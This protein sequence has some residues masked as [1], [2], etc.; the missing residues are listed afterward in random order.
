MFGMATVI[1]AVWKGMKSPS[2]PLSPILFS[3]LSMFSFH[4]VNTAHGTHGF[5]LDFKFEDD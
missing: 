3:F 2:R 4:P 1:Y 5:G